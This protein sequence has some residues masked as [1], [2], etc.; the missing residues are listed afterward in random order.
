MELKAKKQLTQERAALFHAEPLERHRG[1]ELG[2]VGGG[3][4]FM[5]FLPI[6]INRA[7]VLIASEVIRGMPELSCNPVSSH[8]RRRS[9]SLIHCC[10]LFASLR[11]NEEAVIDRRGQGGLCSASSYRRSLARAD[12]GRFL[13]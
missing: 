1:G 2:G 6:M 12:T 7:G 8:L 9:P 11:T 3:Q 13:S 5:E 10:L 4:P